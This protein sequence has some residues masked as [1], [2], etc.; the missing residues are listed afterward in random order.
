MK[1]KGYAFFIFFS[2]CIDEAYANGAH[3]LIALSNFIVT[4]SSYLYSRLSGCEIQLK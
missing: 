3:S 1:E 2:P 4:I